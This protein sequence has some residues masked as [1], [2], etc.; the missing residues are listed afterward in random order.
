[1]RFHPILQILRPHEGIDIDN[2]TGTPVFYAAVDG[3]F[4]F[5]GHQGGYGLAL[6]INHSYSYKTRYGHLSRKYW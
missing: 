5:T 2:E 1:M 4:E 6:E 3:M